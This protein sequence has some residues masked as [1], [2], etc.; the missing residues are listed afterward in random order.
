MG[1]MASGYREI[2]CKDD[3]FMKLILSVS[4]LGRQR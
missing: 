1:A 2:Y 3:L 4:V